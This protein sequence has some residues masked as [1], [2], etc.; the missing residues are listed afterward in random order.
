LFDASPGH[1]ASCSTAIP[2]CSGCKSLWVN[3]RQGQR[4]G[5]VYG[6]K[7]KD[8][9]RY[10]WLQCLRC[11]TCRNDRSYACRQNFLKKGGE[12]WCPP[13]FGLVMT[14]KGGAPG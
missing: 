11:R 6:G 1:E 3:T 4:K 13:G 7:D 8:K 9:E 12:C 14:A 10:E 5:Y 2:G